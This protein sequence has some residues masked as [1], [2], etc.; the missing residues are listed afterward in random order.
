MTA[1]F[2][3]VFAI[4]FQASGEWQR[5]GALKQ[6]GAPFA[7]TRSRLTLA[8]LGRMAGDEPIASVVINEPREQA[9]TLR[10]SLGPIFVM[11]GR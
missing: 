11:I 6:T 1:G 5:V 2:A 9:F 7:S 3:G 4:I 10:V 8:V